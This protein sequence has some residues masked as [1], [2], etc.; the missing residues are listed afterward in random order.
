[1]QTKHLFVLIHTRNKG[2]VGTIFFA[3]RSKMVILLWILFVIC[4]KILQSP[5]PLGLNDNIYND[6]NI[7]KNARLMLFLSFG[8]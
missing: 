2:E 8:I 3:N 7:S 6:G 4:L 1:M 5:F